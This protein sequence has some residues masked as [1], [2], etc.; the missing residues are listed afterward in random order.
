MVGPILLYTVQHFE[1]GGA[2]PN[3]VMYTIAIKQDGDR[4]SGAGL[5]VGCLCGSHCTPGDLTAEMGGRGTKG[6]ALPVSSV[7]IQTQ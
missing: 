6:E 1:G 4:G 2:L 3:E 7:D 5:P